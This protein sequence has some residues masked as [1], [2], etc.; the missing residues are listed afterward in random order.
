[1]P[2][3]RRANRK[4]TLAEI[5]TLT[6][7]KLA[8]S[9]AANQ[10]IDNIASLEAAGPA[11]ISLLDKGEDLAELAATCAG[12]CLMAPRFAASARPGLALLLNERPYAAFVAV[13]RALFASSMLPSS[14]FEASG[15]AAGAYV[16]PSAR[17][18]AG[19]T[20]DP[21]ALIGPRAEIG[22]GTVIA[23]GAGVG[24]DVCVGRQCSVGSG[25][26]I[27]HALIGDRV[28]IHPGAR[29]GQG[30]G[31]SQPDHPRLRRVPQIRRVIVQ[32]DAEIGANATVERGAIRDTVIGEGT[33]IENLAQIAPDVM[34]GRHCR[35]GAQAGIAAGVTIGDFV[36][37]G[38]QA[39]IA[40]DVVVGERATVAGHTMVNEDIPGR[41]RS[42]DVS[43]KPRGSGQ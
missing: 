41:A 9:G 28:T 23:A 43:T 39:G 32:D 12:A 3:L 14:L 26:T 22:A 29:L 31:L 7:S 30:T 10:A 5:A 25:A 27:A 20:V 11:D 36:I 38:G 42:T 19:V 24:S 8:G 6:G 21:L 18:E 17:I 15:R 33:R 4:L 1:M 2:V 13:A 34:I 37:V 40:E 35:I 16:H